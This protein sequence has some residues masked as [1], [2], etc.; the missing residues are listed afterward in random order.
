MSPLK[1][2]VG[3][4]IYCGTTTAPLGREHV[5][6][7]GLGGGYAPDKYENALVLQ[8]A[9]CAACQ[10]IT[11][12]FEGECLRLMMDPARAH[13]DLKRRDRNRGTM[14]AELD[15]PDGSHEN[16][17]VDPSEIPSALVIPA[18]YEAGALTNKPIV[19]NAPCDYKFLIVAPARGPLLNEARRVGVSLQANPKAFAQMLAKI[20]LGVA[21]AKFGINEFKPLVQEFILGK[22]DEYGHWVGG[23]AGKPEQ[24]RGPSLHHISVG[25]MQAQAGVFII[26]E[27]CLFAEFG[28][29]TN[30]VV[31]GQ[32]Q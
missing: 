21:V 2:D 3:Q 16:R 11:G 9:S 31:V 13:L 29:P 8:S 30:Y 20:A 22:A 1:L 19:L 14:I 7:R 18:Y 25:L 17:D 10:R 23:F 27:I 26:A 28:G 32:P 4:C 24:N 15:M 6:P 5:L 12:K